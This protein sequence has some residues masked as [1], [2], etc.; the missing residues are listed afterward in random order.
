MKTEIIKQWLQ[1]NHKRAWAFNN[2]MF[3]AWYTQCEQNLEEGYP[4]L[5]LKSY[6]T[7]NGHT[8]LLNLEDLK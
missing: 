7:N 2:E 6:E 1:D 5:E 8:L 4:Y 3:E